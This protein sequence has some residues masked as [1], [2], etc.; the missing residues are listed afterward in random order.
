MR[1]IKITSVELSF[2]CLG[3]PLFKAVGHNRTEKKWNDWKQ[4]H[5]WIDHDFNTLLT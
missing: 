4:S 2:V 5:L 3:K 1:E